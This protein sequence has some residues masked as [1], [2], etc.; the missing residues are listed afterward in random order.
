[1]HHF[2]VEEGEV[3]FG[4]GEHAATVFDRSLTAAQFLTEKPFHSGVARG[5]PV[6][7]RSRRLN[8]SITISYIF[9]NSLGWSK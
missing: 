5:S 1:M 9:S 7:F 3:V 8:E 2:L 4:V 6:A